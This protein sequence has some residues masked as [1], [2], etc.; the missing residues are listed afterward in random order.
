MHSPTVVHV[1]GNTH[2]VFTSSIIYLSFQG[3]LMAAQAL[4]S[5]VACLPSVQLRC[6]HRR[7]WNQRVCLQQWNYNRFATR[8]VPLSTARVLQTSFRPGLPN[9]GLEDVCG[10]RGEYLRSSIAWI[11]SIKQVNKL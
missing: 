10:P 5:F 9:M 11:V 3:S 6:F 4:M 2:D 8:S 1:G 7:A